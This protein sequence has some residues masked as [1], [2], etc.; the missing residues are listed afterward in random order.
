MLAI[1]RLKRILSGQY[2][3]PSID[4]NQQQQRHVG[5][6][7]KILEPPSSYP[8]PKWLES[9]NHHPEHPLPNGPVVSGGDSNKT[10]HAARS[11]S[12]DNIMS[13]T[14]EQRLYG[15]G[16]S[17]EEIYSKPQI[18]FPAHQAGI[19]DVPS[20]PA[21][22]RGSGT[23]STQYQ[24]D[25]VA[26]QVN[27]PGNRAMSESSD[28][29]SA[30]TH[31]SF[32]SPSRSRHS[33]GEATP[34]YDRGGLS[35]D[36]TDGSGTLKRP[37]VRASPVPKQKSLA[38]IMAAPRRL[39]QE[40][41]PADIVKFNSLQSAERQ[42]DQPTGVHYGSLPRRE[43]HRKNKSTE[44]IYDSPAGVP[45]RVL[46]QHSDQHS[47]SHSP[48]IMNTG[49]GSAPSSPYHT[50]TTFFGGAPGKSTPKKAPPPPPKRTNSIKQAHSPLHTPTHNGASS[51]ENHNKSQMNTL[52]VT[53]PAGSQSPGQQSPSNQSNNLQHSPNRQHSP[54]NSNSTPYSPQPMPLLN[55]AS[56]TS[57][58]KSLADKFRHGGSKD[59]VT[60]ATPPP[61]ISVKPKVQSA[62]NYHTSTHTTATSGQ[63]RQNLSQESLNSTQRNSTPELLRDRNNLKKSNY[64]EVENPL[65]DVIQQLELQVN[66]LG[67]TPNQETGLQGVNNQ[68]T[69][70]TESNPTRQQHSS[71]CSTNNDGNSNENRQYNDENHQNQ[72][73]IHSVASLAAKSGKDAKLGDWQDSQVDSG[74]DSDTGTLER[75]KQVTDLKATDNSCSNEAANPTLE[76][77]SSSGN[78]D[79]NTLPFANENV[80]TIKQRNQTPKPSIVSVSS[81]SDGEGER[82]VELNNSVFSDEGGE[83]GG[84][85]GTI[86]RRSASAS[87][88]SSHHAET[89]AIGE[90][91]FT[92]FFSV[93]NTCVCC[94]CE[95]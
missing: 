48:I 15:Q 45:Q 24:P 71:S 93:I 70:Q 83:E 44:H 5:A 22:V 13:R 14:Q 31:F 82:F 73:S 7:E 52:Q 46:P 21:K 47:A 2:R 41:G 88:C 28:S 59:K 38:Q 30:R 1:D 68:E 33:S 51:S 49:R 58:V 12:L 29:E 72:S 60:G 4:Q 8:T 84:E 80:G 27:H 61:P 62:G 37:S 11:P 75:K 6:Q 40:L 81:G 54:S 35:G 66:S 19:H 23:S 90:W 42:Q 25:V 77:T 10:P 55:T 76:R 36:E 56:Y 63:E 95:L 9:N 39:S 16:L 85:T 92:Y 20:S 43:S 18:G 32:Q 74:S 50:S 67:P 91:E 78:I 94:L 87:T 89:S 79:S 65:N 69:N 26:I 53:I 34:T 57:G 3:V 86:K 64:A 17:R